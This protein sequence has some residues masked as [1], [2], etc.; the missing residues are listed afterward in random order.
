MRYF[1]PLL[2]GLAVSSCT[3]APPAETSAYAAR[4]QAKLAQLTA[5]KVAGAPTNCLPAYRQNDMVIIDDNTIAFR[6]G[7]K[8]VYVNHLNGGCNNLGYGHYALVTHPLTS[9]LCRGDIA[10]VVDL[11]NHITVGSCVIGDFVPYTMAGTRY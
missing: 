7:R 4:Q 11:M 5:G 10:Q 1:V 8:R 3:A 9:Q 2:A 6:E